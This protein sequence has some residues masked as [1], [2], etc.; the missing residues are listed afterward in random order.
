MLTKIG[1]NSIYGMSN[2]YLTIDDVMSVFDEFMCE[3]VDEVGK[4]I[5]LKMLRDKA[6]SEV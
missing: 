2:N 1:L 4:E 5:F 6:E 3:E